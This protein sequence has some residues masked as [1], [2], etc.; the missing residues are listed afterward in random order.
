MMHAPD[1]FHSGQVWSF[2]G[3]AFRIRPGAKGP[4]DCVMEWRGV[5]GWR[6]IPMAA[7]FLVVDFLTWNE[8]YLYP[9]PRRGGEELFRYFTIARINGWRYATA[10]LEEARRR[11]G[12]G[13]P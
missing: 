3:V 6:P 9:N 2:A 13:Q 12:E 10:M 4:R 11:R 8:D 1:R 5:N 7:L